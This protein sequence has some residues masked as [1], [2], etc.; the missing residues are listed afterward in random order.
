MMTILIF[1]AAVRPDGKPSTALRRR[2]EAALICAQA[3]DDARFIPTGAIGRH[4]PSEASVMAGL[5]ME[6]GVRSERILLEESG[7]DTLSSVRALARLLRESPSGGR[8]MV[9]TSPYHQPRCLLLLCLFGIAA[10][11]CAFPRQPSAAWTKRWYWRLR[12]VPAVPYDAVLA[13]W[14]RLRG[15]I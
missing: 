5:L 8:V 9:A 2:V 3:H 15:R 4:G 7:F 11:P 10:R 14:E 1:G 6:S 13:L 12:E